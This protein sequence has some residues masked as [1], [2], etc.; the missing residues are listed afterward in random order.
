MSIKINIDNLSLNE[1]SNIVKNLQFN[2]KQN[3]RFRNNQVSPSIH[4]YYIDDNT[5]DAYLPFYWCMMN[6]KK[7]TRPL[8][9]EFKYNF[10]PTFKSSL[11]LRP[12]Q[13]EVKKKVIKFLNDIGTCWLSLYTGGGKTFIATNIAT[14]IKLKTLVICHRVNLINQWKKSIETSC[15]NVI[16][17]ILSGV[18]TY[19]VNADFYIIN[20]INVKKRGQGFFKEIGFLVVDE[21][22]V[23][24]TERMSEAFQYITPRY[25]LALSATPYRSDGLDE[26]LHTFF[27]T[28]KIIYEMHKSHTVFKVD[29]GFVPD[30]K[31]NYDGSTD[32][33]SVIQSQCLNEDRNDLII[34]LVTFFKERNFLIL[35][36]RIEQIDYIVGK[37]RS[38]GEDVTS[39]KGNKQTYNCESRILVA[40]ISK[41]GV[42]FD[43]PKMDA[44]VLASDVE[45]YFM[46]YL[47][48][49]FRR[50]DVHPIIFDLVDNFNS[51]KRHYYTRKHTYEKSGGKIHKFNMDN[52]CKI[53][54]N[55]NKDK[56]MKIFYGI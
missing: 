29:T 49:V 1:R 16:V 15:D 56:F 48:R 26:I 19:D 32:W 53:V 37:L 22:H 3:P 21:V 12:L 11:T 44:L 25:C 28:N 41:A 5:N 35:S 54:D 2:K 6:V 51:L 9:N 17:Q 10:T 33:S 18:N 24:G 4:P 31:L 14:C 50:E 38:L 23:M 30:Y 45:E 36:K 40:T 20:A 46:Q 34:N 27:S 52:V 13:K 47:G 8:R 39:F 55:V 42:G 43:H 7:C